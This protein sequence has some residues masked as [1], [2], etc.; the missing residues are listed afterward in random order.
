MHPM[1][2]RLLSLGAIGLIL[3]FSFDIALHIA[4]QGCCGAPS[5][6]AEGVPLYPSQEVQNL[7]LIGLIVVDIAAI[8]L[9]LRWGWKRPKPKA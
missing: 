9:V 4:L 8:W 3:V 2:R 1:L 5:H 7:E 6:T